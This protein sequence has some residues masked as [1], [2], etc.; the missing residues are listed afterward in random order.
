MQRVFAIHFALW[1][2]S[3]QC[4]ADTRPPALPQVDSDILGPLQAI[5]YSRLKEADRVRLRAELFALPAWE[6]RLGKVMAEL[7]ARARYDG[8][9]DRLSVERD[10]VPIDP[11]NPEAG[12]ARMR[13]I[14][15]MIEDEGVRRS[16][17]KDARSR[18]WQLLDNLSAVRDKRVFSLIA[19]LLFEKTAVISEGPYRL[20]STQTKAASSLHVLRISS[21]VPQKTPEGADV[22]DWLRWWKENRKDYAP[23]PKALAALE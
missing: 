13:E 19:P 16:D 3:L 2:F 21:P 20:D 15:K 7:A 8:K 10:A 23:V 5:T 4:V 22:D 11:K 18:L 12:I 14:G 17:A 1:F 9:Y 6:E